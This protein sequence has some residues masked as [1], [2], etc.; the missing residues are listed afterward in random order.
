ME[1]DLGL[2]G[3]PKHLI[4]FIRCT[5]DG[6]VLELAG[7]SGTVSGDNTTVRSGKLVC[8]GCAAEF[9]IEKGILN[10]LDESALDE[11]SAHEQRTRNTD[12]HTVDPIDSTSA[13]E[14]NEMAMLP[15]LEEL[16]VEPEQKVLEL[17]CGEGRYTMAL[18]GRVNVVAVD[19]AI[20]LLRILQRRLPSGSNGVALVLGDISTL[21][22]AL[23]QFDFTLS[24]LT[25]N[26]PSREHRENLY[27]LAR[28]A[29]NAR[30]RFVF[31]SHF[32]GFRQRLAGQSKSGRYRDGGIYR[33]NFG[34]QE[35]IDEVTPHFSHVRVRPIQIRFPF[36]GRLKLPLVRLS[37]MLEHVPVLNRFGMLLLGV[38]T[39]P[40]GTLRS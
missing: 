15:T 13:R 14:H 17:G 5:R 4:P 30:G 20:E 27:R 28:G 18:A 24:T 21:K 33:Y 19:F 8:A 3:F 35:S 2:P 7:E 1:Q 25:S 26:L 31:C 9:F 6:G 40:R 39:A 22:V 23:Q 38:A 10:L 34:L 32:H 11:E 36:A 29:L 12:L 16:P 37:R